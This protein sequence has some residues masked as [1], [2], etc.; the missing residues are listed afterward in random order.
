MPRM[1][2]RRTR[3]SKKTSEV[4][5]LIMVSIASMCLALLVIYL[6]IGGYTDNWEW[7]T[8]DELDKLKCGHNSPTSAP[9]S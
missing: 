6:C 1:S 7:L 9:T 3:R 2:R 5:N 4:E 8:S